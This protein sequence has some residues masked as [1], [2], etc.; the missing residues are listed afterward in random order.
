[1]FTTI[2]LSSKKCGQEVWARAVVHA[3]AK[4]VAAVR[5]VALRDSAFMFANIENFKQRKTPTHPNG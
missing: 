4:N 5:N 2:G 1:M 3:R